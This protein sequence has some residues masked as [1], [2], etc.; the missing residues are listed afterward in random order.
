MTEGN[1]ISAK[2]R[3]QYVYF[4]QIGKDGP[5]KIGL[6]RNGHHRLIK[7][8]VGC[9]WK[10][11]YLNDI[12]G[13]RRMEKQLQRRFKHLRMRGEWFHPGPDLLLFIESLFPPEVLHMEALHQQEHRRIQEEELARAEEISL[14]YRQR[15]A[16]LDHLECLLT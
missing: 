13:D 8:Q 6:T 10:L 1:H 14:A 7:L 4:F 11:H 2:P 12:K 16:E 9:P 5:I 15:Q 3:L